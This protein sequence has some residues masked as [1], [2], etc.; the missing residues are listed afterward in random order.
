MAK[1]TLKNHRKIRYESSDPKIAALNAKTGKVT[2]K[3]AGTCFI[4]VYSQ[5]GTFAKVKLTVK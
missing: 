5:S 4:Y 3:K 2:A 1:L